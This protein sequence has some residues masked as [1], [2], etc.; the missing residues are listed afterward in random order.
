M[1][2][3]LM[4]TLPVASTYALTEQQLDRYAQNNILFYDP[5]GGSNCGSGAGMVSGDNQNYAGDIIFTEENLKAI[6]ANRPFYEKSAAKYG[7]PWQVLAVIHMR[8]HSLARSNPSNGQGAYQLYSYTNGGT[9]AN[10][11]KPAGAISDDEF[12]RQS[13]IAA[14]VVSEKAAGLDLTTD[15][16]LKKMFFRY[17]SASSAYVNQGVALGF[18]EADAA[19]GEGSPYVMNRFDEKRDP[20]REPTKSNNTWGQIKTDNS[21]MSYPANTDFGAFVYYMALGGTISNTGSVCTSFAGGNMNL[22]ET[23]IGLAWPENQRRESSSSPTSAYAEAI[24]SS[25]V[26]TAEE[27]NVAAAGGFKRPDGKWIPVGKSCDNFVATVVKYSGVDPAFPIWLGGQKSYLEKSSMWEKV[28]V[29][30]SSSARPGDIRIEND[31]GHIVMVVEVDGVLKIASASS[32]E[33]FGDINGYYF[34]RGVN[35]RLRQ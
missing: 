21:S 22:N 18:S 34:A 10:A 35:Y 12:Q 23:A 15:A 11:F 6:E 24:R 30:D 14:G 13:D 17:N 26:T 33:R 32:G 2:A 8:E 25:W 31:G 5:N 7:F 29:N 3:F 19:N 9:N 1:M 16:G 4:G 20:T 28:T 27:R